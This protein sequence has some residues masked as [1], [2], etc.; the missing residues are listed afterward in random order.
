MIKI[1]G[2]ILMCLYLS[3]CTLDDPINLAHEGAKAGYLDLT[4]YQFAENGILKLN[5]EWELY[6]KHFVDARDFADRRVVEGQYVQVPQNWEEYQINNKPLSLYGYAT[7]R[8]RVKVPDVDQVY[9]LRLHR[10]FTS[11]K[12]W[13]DG[14]LYTTIGEISTTEEKAKAKAKLMPMSVFFKAQQPEVELILQVSNHHYYQGGI[15]DGIEMGTQDQIVK[16]SHK[17]WVF[18]LLLAGIILGIGIYH[19]ILYFVVRKEASPFWFGMICLTVFIQLIFEGQMIFSFTFS[20]MSLQME[21]TLQTIEHFIIIPS[22]LRMMYFLFNKKMSL[23]IVKL[24][25][26]ISIVAVI[27]LVLLPFGYLYPIWTVYSFV[28]L[29]VLVYIFIFIIKSMLRKEENAILAFAG[30]TIFASTGIYDLLISLKVFSPPFLMPF[31]LQIFI[32]CQCLIIARK[33]S[34]AFKKV[35]LLSENL[36]RSNQHLKKAYAEVDQQV[37]ERTEE[38]RNAKGKIEKMNQQ[39]LQDKILLE[40]Q[41]NIDGLTGL[42]NKSFAQNKLMDEINQSVKN[43]RP[44]AVCMLDLDLFKQV[45][46]TFGHLV[47]DDVLKGVSR[48]MMECIR[49]TDMA[50]RY[51]GEEFVIV[52]PNTDVNEGYQL[53]EKIRKTVE[54]LDWDIT[55]LKVTISGG[56]VQYVIN[57]EQDILQQAD[58]LLYKAKN[59]GRNRVER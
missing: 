39:L 48:I 42:Y 36:N 55:G 11:Y 14:E 34:R 30:Y 25:D 43:N 31:G 54:K 8:L 4:D 38:L 59:R 50:A 3:G 32:F 29:F 40:K 56:V 46:D 17:R 6:W 53:M 21:E 45:N 28:I 27:A 24:V 44:L 52:M 18:D 15:V 47:G 5:G 23:I 49:E 16:L 1:F 20:S 26:T 58:C 13:I 57:H 2:L 9:G 41:V 51:G 12:L 35:Q 7:Y 37:Q 10:I 22:L 19:M 33:Y